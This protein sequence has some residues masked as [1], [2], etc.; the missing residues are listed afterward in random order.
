MSDIS[1]SRLHAIIKYEKDQF[2]IFDN[3]SKFGTL[4]LMKEPF[5]LS[6]DKIGVQIG[7]TVISLAHKSNE[8]LLKNEVDN[9]ENLNK[10]SA[11]KTIVK[12]NSSENYEKKNGKNSLKSK[13][14]M[15]PLI[16]KL[17]KLE[18]KKKDFEEED[19]LEAF[20]KNQQEDVE[21]EM[22]NEAN[23]QNE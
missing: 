19:I 20:E 3:N 11:L 15:G 1:V 7:R 14:N 17:I 21:E 23:E 16:N 13:D 4:V 5:V 8:H 9:F 22:E 18:P 10:I 12:A 2:R 6:S